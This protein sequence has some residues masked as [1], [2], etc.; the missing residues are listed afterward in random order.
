VATSRTLG[1][2]SHSIPALGESGWGAALSTYLIAIADSCLATDGGTRSL[3]AELNLGTSFGIKALYLKSTGPNIGS[4]GV[5]RLA[6]AESIVWR[7]AANAADLPLT[8]NSSNVLQ[9]NSNAVATAASTLAHFAAT[10][11]AELAGVISDETGSGSLVFATSPTLV[12]PALGVATGTSLQ[13]SGLTASR[14]LVTD[15][16]KNLTSSAVTETEL[17]YLSGVSAPTGSGALV[18]ATSPSLVTPALGVA[19]ATSINKVAITAPA[20]SATL[21]LADGKTLTVSNTLTFTG[22]DSSS[23][24]F[25]AGGTVA[26]TANKLSAF[27]ATTS[28]ELA[29]VISD[30]TGSG[31]LVFGTSPTFTT[32]A[33]LA[34]QG[35]LRLADS[36]SSKYV[37]LKAPATVADNLVWTLPDADGEGNQALST[38]G[39]GNLIWQTVASSS[40]ATASAQ[41]LVTSYAPTVKSSVKIVSGSGGYDILDNDGYDVIIVTYGGA[42][43]TINLPTAA[44]NTGR[45]LTLIK[46]ND[47]S[48]ITFFEG[49]G[50]EEVNGRGSITLYRPYSSCTIVCDGTSWYTTTPATPGSMIRCQGSSNGYGSTNTAIR[51]FATSPLEEVG[52]GITYTDSATAGASFTINETGVYTIHYTDVRSNADVTWFQG[53]S[54]N[55]SQL[56]TGIN[57][58]T[59]SNRLAYRYEVASGSI[60]MSVS[61]TVLCVE[62]D[63]IRAHN[64]ATSA[65]SAS[66]TAAELTSFTITQVSRF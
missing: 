49:E 60:W 17:G 58:L 4:T 41:G 45:K 29:S 25:G 38:D 62:G 2:V 18:L 16:S 26:Y 27:A 50:S 33:T 19:S 21:T 11:S 54:K 36:D 10:T 30:E 66:T 23:V 28:A 32:S 5:I 9:F 8:V 20:S 24:A 39:D 12:T 57:S 31:A 48:Y 61:A 43:S 55:S 56:T 6:N 34:A 53:I 59:A 44:D 51:R 35:E 15:G 3:T 63:V 64:A 14:A 7:N 13:L 65:N 52:T 1:G 47:S 22:T 46:A 37:G 42:D 40:T